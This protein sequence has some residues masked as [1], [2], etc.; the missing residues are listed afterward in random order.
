MKNNVVKQ[1]LKF[2]LVMTIITGFIY[3]LACTAIAQIIFPNKANGSIIYKNDKPVASE[4]IGQEFTS[5]RYFWSRPSTTSPTPYNGGSSSGSNKTP[6]GKELEDMVQQR[7]KLIRELDPDN[8]QK[9]P[10]DFITA[11][12]SGL[13]PHIS[14]AAALYQVDRI[15][16]VRNIDKDTL[17]RLIDKNT[18]KRQLG[19]LGEPR[20][21]VVK[22]NIDIDNL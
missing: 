4:L 9:I 16:K 6:A 2:V 3:P 19:I 11:S 18:E 15:S 13:D 20:V 21:N 14:P 17:I 1:S 22:L 10:V 7:I 8:N 12:G 5:D